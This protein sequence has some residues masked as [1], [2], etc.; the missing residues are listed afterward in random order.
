MGTSHESRH[1]DGSEIEFFD[2]QGVIN[3]DQ[4]SNE[5]E[6]FGEKPIKPGQEQAFRGTKDVSRKVLEEDSD[7]CDFQALPPPS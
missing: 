1:S 4:N 7:N 6:S 5:Q 3:S 2:M